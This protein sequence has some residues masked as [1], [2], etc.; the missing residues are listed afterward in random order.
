MIIM[1]GLMEISKQ[2]IDAI[3][4]RENARKLMDALAP[5]SRVQPTVG[6]DAAD[7]NAVISILVCW[8]RAQRKELRRREAEARRDLL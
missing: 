3:V 2:E 6:I 4:I 7:L 5:L 8:E 1:N